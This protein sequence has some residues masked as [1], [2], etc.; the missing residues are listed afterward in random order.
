MIQGTQP[1]GIQPVYPKPEVPV[2]LDDIR[3][4]ALEKAEKADKTQ[5]TELTDMETLAVAKEV[6]EGKIEAYK[7]GA[8]V[9]AEVQIDTQNYIKTLDT[10]EDY[11]ELN[12]AVK[13]KEAYGAFQ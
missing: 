5:K 11:R 2:N 8:G 9:E 13:A 1:I 6:Q 7:A 4:K 10:L 3:D 12:N